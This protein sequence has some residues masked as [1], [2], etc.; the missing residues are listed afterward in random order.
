MTP[1]A[2]LLRAECRKAAD[3]RAARWLLAATVLLAIAAQAVPLVFPHDVTEDRASFLT[4]AALGMTRLL[5]IALILT[6]TAEW[7]QRTALITFTLEPRR[8][9]VLAAKVLAGL[10]LAVIGGCLAFG[11]AQAGLAVAVAAGHH[12]GTGWSGQELAGFAVFMLA[13]S[14]IG[15]AIGSAVHN[16]AAAIVTYFALAALASVLLIPAVQRIGNYANPNQVLGWVL[17]GDWAEHGP[18]IAS[19][20]VIWIALPLAIGAVRTLRR[21]VA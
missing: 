12:P 15:I 1:F 13:T 8:G 10:V 18:Q 17:N 5:P 7:S 19:C 4:W 3:T 21:D 11:I 2:R 16:T 9:R 6:M 20:A 14:G